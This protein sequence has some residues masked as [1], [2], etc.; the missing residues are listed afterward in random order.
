MFFVLRIHVPSATFQQASKNSF[1]GMLKPEDFAVCCCLSQQPS[2]LKNG[3]S[4]Q[5][6]DC[7]VE[8]NG[9]GRPFP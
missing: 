5:R 1:F 9:K 3:D 6:R 8:G 7:G 4:Q 2:D